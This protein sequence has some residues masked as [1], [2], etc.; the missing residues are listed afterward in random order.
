VRQG[1]RW[2]LAALLAGACAREVRKDVTPPLATD[3]PQ[4][5]AGAAADQDPEAGPPLSTQEQIDHALSRVTFGPRAADRERV[6]RIGV[7]A[8][9]EEQLHPEAIADR[10]VQQQLARFPVLRR[11]PAEL[12]EELARY[13]KQKREEK[14]KAKAT[15]MASADPTAD[16]PDP[17]LA[18][19]ALPRPGQRDLRKQLGKAGKGPA[20]EMVAQLTQAKLVR[21]IGS[22]RQLQE[23][24]ADFWFNHFNVFAGKENEAALL[25][26]YEQEIRERA[27]GRFGDLLAAT[28][29]SPAM[30]VY[31]DNWRS[32]TPLP[33]GG[34]GSGQAALRNPNP[35]LNESYA[36]ELLELHTLGVYGGYT[37]QDIVE[38]AR[39]FTG[40]TVAEPQRDPRYVFRAGMH[41]PGPKLVLGR[42]I[43]AGGE[44]DGKAVLD[45]LAHHPS[46]ARHISRKLVQRFVS[47]DPPEAL[48]QRAADTFSSTGGDVRSVLRTIFES[49]ELWSRRALRAKVRSPLEL[50]AGS[51]RALGARIEDPMALA[52]AVARIGQPLFAAQPP[53]G[54]P[55]DAA[56]WLSSDALLARIDFGL[57]L[58][59]GQM[60]GVRVDLAPLARDGLGPAE[61][62]DRAAARLGMPALSDRTRRY[63]LAQ[64]R[65]APPRP[66]LVASRALGLLLGSPELQRR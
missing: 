2:V 19:R 5:A 26:A 30:L 51:V 9:L 12:A 61:A 56:G 17:N 46:T 11:N 54:Y 7:A 62:L 6:A 52:R 63:V 10:V 14:A 49:P 21:A 37:Q 8:F 50:V 64:L 15:A 20:F 59:S 42:E 34:A 58:A 23:V 43:A 28:A 40:W 44:D 24:M 1:V 25:P 18:P 65:G 53:T 38:V 39:C 57:A 29:H 41:D 48:V 60:E 3:A 36:R 16:P 47:D 55:D 4:A 32:S 35:G 22:E 45:L 33:Q 66:H 13:R 27:L 31:L